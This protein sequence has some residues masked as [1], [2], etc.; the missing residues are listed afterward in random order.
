MY[1]ISILQQHR[2]LVQEMDS[3]A[4]ALRRC[5]DGRPAGIR[6]ASAGKERVQETGHRDAMALQQAEF[7][8]HELR[9][10][11]EQLKA[12]QPAFDEAIAN[13]RDWRLRAA[14]KLYYGLGYSWQEAAAHC[15]MSGRTLQM[16]AKIET[17]RR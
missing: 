13:I 12:M 5:T 17:H 4:L 1:E 3:L 15:G 11:S 14:C 9:D 6:T 10:I 8:E 16:L 7:L 2:Q